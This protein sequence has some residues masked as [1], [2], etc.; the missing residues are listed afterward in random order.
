[1]RIINKHFDENMKYK[2]LI[3]KEHKVT[4]EYKLLDQSS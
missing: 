3:Q 2:H 1:M 4:Y